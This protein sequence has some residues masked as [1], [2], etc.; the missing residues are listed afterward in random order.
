ME[1][2]EQSIK[3]ILSQVGEINKNEIETLTGDS[4]LRNIGIDSLT[5]I[6]LVVK[7]E[8]SFDI[9]IGDDDLSVDNVSTINA[10]IELIKKY[11]E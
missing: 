1:I 11:A 10:I 4:D 9:S 5:S 8:E 2:N 6:E 3:E 7:L